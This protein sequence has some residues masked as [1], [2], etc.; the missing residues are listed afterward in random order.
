MLAF[1]ALPRS[2]TF[3]SAIWKSITKSSG[4]PC[5]SALPEDKPRALELSQ[6]FSRNKLIKRIIKSL[7][8]QIQQLEILSYMSEFE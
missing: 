8:H 2:S 1:V 5:A 3:L 4:E 7:T 6:S